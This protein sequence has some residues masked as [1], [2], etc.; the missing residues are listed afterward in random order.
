MNKKK[1]LKLLII[2]S[3]LIIIILSYCR[4]D[5]YAAAK[6]FKYSYGVFLSCNSGKSTFK[7]FKNYKTIILDVQN[8]FSENDIKKLKKEGHI[9]YSYL[10]IGSVEKYR[11]Y[12]NSYK[13][14]TLDVY[15]NWPD[16]RWVDVSSEKW[17]KFILEDLSSQIANTGVDGFFIDNVDVYYQYHNEN[18]YSGVETILKGLKKK[19]KV[20]INGGDTFVTEYYDRNK[21]LDAILDGINQESVFSKI[22]DY[23]KNEFGQNNSSDIKYFKKYLKLLK[24]EKKNCY[25]LEYTKDKKLKTKIK[26]YC[27]KHG[28][29]YY[30]SENLNL[31]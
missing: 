26:K 12:Y 15:E 3:L 14:I 5:S 20:I 13:D 29:K 28:Y 16:E 1:I 27:K 22:I 18:I 10:N 4:V 31:S 19:G 11:D 30:I 7:K 6:K 23:D 21:S 25:L 9:V 8:D 2:H 17:Q 24:K